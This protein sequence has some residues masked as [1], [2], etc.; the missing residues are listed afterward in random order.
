[1][2]KS[3]RTLAKKH[4]DT[5]MSTCR[6]TIQPHRGIPVEWTEPFQTG[7]RDSG[8]G[9]FPLVGNCAAR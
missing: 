7:F 9:M 1:M 3:M 5:H 8:T 2:Q 6:S 4:E